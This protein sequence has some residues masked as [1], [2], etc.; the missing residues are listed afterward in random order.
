MHQSIEEKF[1]CK[2]KRLKIGQILRWLCGWEGIRIIESE[3]CPNC[4]RKMRALKR[5]KDLN[6]L[7]NKIL[8]YLLLDNDTKKIELFKELFKV[9]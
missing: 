1:F 9:C 7:Q 5:K 3:V 2:S 4:Y 8:Y 6:K